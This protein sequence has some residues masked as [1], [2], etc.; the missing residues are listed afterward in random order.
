MPQEDG[1]GSNPP[2]APHRV[3][4]AP[5]LVIIPCP[6]RMV[7]KGVELEIW[8]LLQR[9]LGEV[10]LG[11]WNLPLAWPGMETGT[12]CCHPASSLLGALVQIIC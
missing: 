3:H 4:F 1:A 5:F 11:S 2:S 9:C 6:T 10:T 7:L 8:S 12:S